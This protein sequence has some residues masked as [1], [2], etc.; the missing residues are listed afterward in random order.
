MLADLVEVAKHF[1][2]LFF[3]FAFSS[4]HALSTCSRT[5]LE[6]LDRQTEHNALLYV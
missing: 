4:F 6:P 1:F 2:A 3:S 5:L